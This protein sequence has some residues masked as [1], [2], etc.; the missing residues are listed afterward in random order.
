MDILLRRIDS[1]LPLPEYKTAGAAAFDLYARE[2]TVVPAGEIRVIPLNVAM[3]LPDNHWAMLAARGSLF[4]KGLRLANGVGI[5]DQDFCGNDDEYRA[6][7]QNF[8]DQPV[9]VTRGERIV[10]AII[11]PMLQLNI[12]E[13][14]D[15]AHPSRGGFGTTSTH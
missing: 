10:Q 9:T 7:V 4:K 6:V 2:E 15:L 5:M 1:S 3:K 14:A 13:V 11:L 8:T 12:Q